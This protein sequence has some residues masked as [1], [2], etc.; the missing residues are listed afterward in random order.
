[1]KTYIRDLFELPERVGK[2]DFVLAL[3]RGVEHAGETLRSYVVTEQLASAFDDALGFISGALDQRKSRASYLHGSFGSG[4]SHFMAV[5]HLLLQGNVQARSIPELASVVTKHQR[6]L[7]GKRFLLV[8]YHMIGAHSME[9]AILGHYAEHIEKLH[10]EAPVPPVYLAEAL[11]KDAQGLRNHMGD[12]SFFDALNKGT[13][14]ADGWGSLAARWDDETFADALAAPARDERRLQLV[15]ALIGTL[16][17]SYAQVARSG[18]ESFVSLDR[19]L[20]IISRHAK[21]LGYDA[22]ILFLDE[23]IL[24]LASRAADL[25][26]VSQE[27]E[28]LVKLIEAESADRP[29][30][31]VSFVARQRDL[32]ELVGDH[33]AGADQLRFADSLSH[34][35]GR[36]HRIT[37]EDRNLPK[38]A[39]K[40]VHPPK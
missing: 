5:L 20:A 26:F 16:F 19:G 32:R 2:G 10:A 8:P 1:M 11:F 12:E 35:E 38:I 17:P 31:I 7:G 29:I 13:E 40:R 22:V 30:P 6:W 14:A 25:S 18:S 27:G 36:F 39:E 4:K 3:T 24:W 28:K 21:D 23:L 15:S 9:S 33:V 34:W 37:L